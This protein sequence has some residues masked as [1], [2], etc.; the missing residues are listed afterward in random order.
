MCGLIDHTPLIK[1]NILCIKNCPTDLMNYMHNSCDCRTLFDVA[2]KKQRIAVI[3][4]IVSDPDFW[5]DQKKATAITKERENLSVEV[6][7]VMAL[8]KN[9]ADHIEL[10]AMIDDEKDLAPVAGEVDLLEKGVEELTFYTL[11]DGK[12]DARD[13]IVTIRAGAGGDDAQDWSEMLSRMY[14]RWAQLHGFSTEIFDRTLGSEAG[15]KSMTFQVSGDRVF[16]WLRGEAGVHRLVRLSPFNSD[17]LRQTSFAQVEILPIID[18]MPEVEI[19]SDDLKIDTFRSS[20]AGGQSVN[21]TDSAVRIT[22]IPSGIV[23]SCQNERSQ[24]QNKLQA[25]TILTAKLHQR[26]IEQ[27]DERQR[28]L[29]G[30]QKSAQWGSQIRSYVL[31]P[32]KL[33]KDHRTKYESHNV[34]DVLAGGIDAFISAYLHGK[35]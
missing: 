34:E 24:L 5:S 3:D 23:V 8:E 31:H 28:V 11:F 35:L 21:T 6:E 12:Y 33:V 15:I 29:R 20:G 14:L 9:I 22:H 25:M 16:G 4:Q 19:S 27:E 1:E 32:Y 17:N 30:E 10:L 2:S 13:A 7:K 26:Y 18:S